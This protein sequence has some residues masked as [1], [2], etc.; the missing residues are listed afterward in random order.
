M[1]YLRKVAMCFTENYLNSINNSHKIIITFLFSLGIFRKI[2]SDICVVPLQ[3]FHWWVFPF[4]LWRSKWPNCCI[5]I[6]L[7]KIWYRQSFSIWLESYQGS[8]GSQNLY[9]AWL[10]N[11]NDYFFLLY[12]KLCSLRGAWLHVLHHQ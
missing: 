12:E 6:W 5:R 2:L 8:T 1:Q 10:S 4:T 7:I 11:S 3:I 9:L